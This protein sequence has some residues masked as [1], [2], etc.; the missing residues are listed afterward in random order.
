MADK[1]FLV[2]CDKLSIVGSFLPMYTHNFQ[3]FYRSVFLSFLQP[4]LE[5]NESK[6]VGVS[7]DFTFTD[8]FMINSSI[9][10]QWNTV[11]YK[12]RLEFNPNLIT[13]EDKNLIHSILK[14]LTDLHITR[15]DVAVDL[16]NYNLELYNITTLKPLKKAYYHDRVGQLETVYLGSQISSRFFRIYNKAKEQK[17]TNVNWWRVE[18]QLRQVYIDKFLHGYDQFFSDILIYRY[19]SNIFKTLGFNQKAILDYLLQD[20]NRFSE[21]T[22]FRTKLKYKKLIRSLELESLTFINDLVELSKHDLIDMINS[23][24]E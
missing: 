8:S 22:D 7:N 17:L 18:L 13:I 2:S 1:S 12:V 15:L 3:D 4:L 11:N 19:N 14:Y 6:V 5:V 20:M 16:Y 21:L 23:Y 10:L 9:F 24:I